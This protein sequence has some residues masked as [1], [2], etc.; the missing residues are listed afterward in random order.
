MRSMNGETPKPEDGT[1]QSGDKGI[2]GIEKKLDPNAVYREIGELER[3]FNSMQSI[4]RGLASTWFLAGYAGVGFLYSTKSWNLE[5]VD[6]DVAASLTCLAA[7]TGICLLWLVDVRVYHTLLLALLE[8]AKKFESDFEIP[9]FR[10]RAAQATLGPLRLSIR[11]KISLFYAIPATLLWCSALGFFIFSFPPQNANL[12][13]RVPMVF[14][15][16]LTFL[17]LIIM[18]LERR[19]KETDDGGRW[20]EILNGLLK[21]LKWVTER[22]PK[23]RKTR[24]S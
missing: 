14:W 19:P 16:V 9:A 23:R 4:Y 12:L 7:A 17:W 18:Y 8:R 2:E 1:L 11:A 10:T 24:S 6:K 13:V 15:F 21:P 22:A 3:H 20:K 5:I